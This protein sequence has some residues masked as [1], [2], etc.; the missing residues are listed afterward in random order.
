MDSLGSG[1]TSA[2]FDSISIIKKT[3]LSDQVFIDTIGKSCWYYDSYSLNPD[4]PK[5]DL[6]IGRE[7]DDQTYEYV[8]TNKLDVYYYI[9]SL[10]L[11]YDES[12]NSSC[13]NF[14]ILTAM[15]F[16]LNGER[17]ETSDYYFD[18]L[19]EK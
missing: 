16:D 13:C 7:N 6:Y 2:E 17:M 14:S 10:F 9:D 8:I 15:N 3:I 4:F 1:F 19:I 12:E 5:C 18:L 11:D